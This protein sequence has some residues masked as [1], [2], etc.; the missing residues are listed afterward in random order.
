MFN[1]VYQLRLSSWAKLLEMVKNTPPYRGT[2]NKYPLG[3][4]KFSICYLLLLVVNCVVYL[5]IFF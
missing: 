3:V 4:R 2:T 1:D 5:L